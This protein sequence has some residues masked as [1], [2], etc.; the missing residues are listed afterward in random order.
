MSNGKFMEYV[1]EQRRIGKSNKQIATS[2]GMSLKHFLSQVGKATEIKDEMPKETPRV[3]VKA[4]EATK[5]TESDKDPEEP[6]VVLKTKPEDDFD[7]MD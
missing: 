1:N 3:Q 5:K 4:K 2:L 6:V 7:W